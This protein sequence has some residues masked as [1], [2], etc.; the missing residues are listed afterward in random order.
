MKTNWTANESNLIYTGVNYSGTIIP[1]CRNKKIEFDIYFS[2]NNSNKQTPIETFKSLSI[3]INN[4]E[5]FFT[6]DN[7]SQEEKFNAKGI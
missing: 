2:E 7:L 4:I 3:A 6:L 1:V 5:F